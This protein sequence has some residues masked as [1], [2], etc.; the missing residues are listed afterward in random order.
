[1]NK[2]VHGGEDSAAVRGGGKNQMSVTE[3]ILNGLGLVVTS[4]VGHH[5]AR[6]P[7]LLEL[8]LKQLDGLVGGYSDSC[9]A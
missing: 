8:F 2:V 3:G 1:M 4:E 9:A 6:A 7:L 5:N